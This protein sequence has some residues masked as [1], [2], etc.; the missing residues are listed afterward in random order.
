M[1]IIDP[2]DINPAW[3]RVVSAIDVGD[4]EPR[5]WLGPLSPQ[6]DGQRLQAVAQ[7]IYCLTTIYPLVAFAHAAGYQP[8]QCHAIVHRPE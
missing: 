3:L 5:W 1:R 4:D 7:G 2:A 6:L 8:V